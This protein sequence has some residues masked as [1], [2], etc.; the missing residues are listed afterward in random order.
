MRFEISLLKTKENKIWKISHH[1]HQ[2]LL[3]MLHCLIRLHR[4][5][6]MLFK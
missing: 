3:G 2:N 6:R 4:L 1:Y 5:V